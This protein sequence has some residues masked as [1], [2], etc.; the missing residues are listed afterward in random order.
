[1]LSNRDDV[2]DMLEDLALFYGKQDDMNTRRIDMYVRSLADVPSE[3]RRRA[4]DRWMKTERWFPKPSELR[5]IAKALSGVAHSFA[6][7]YA[8]ESV[9][10]TPRQVDMRLKADYA[11]GA[12]DPEAWRLAIEY[13]KQIGAQA[14][15]D[16]LQ[17]RLDHY[18]GDQPAAVEQLAEVPA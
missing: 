16:G 13:L 6:A 7:E 8:P 5:E 9:R 3:L 17:E 2:L 18:Q 12:F 11:R 4:A 1:M 14:W 15:A 10:E